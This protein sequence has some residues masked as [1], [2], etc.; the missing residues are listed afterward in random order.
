M[1]T[2]LRTPVL[3]LASGFL[4]VALPSAAQECPRL[5][6]KF[7]IPREP[8]TSLGP[9]QF[10]ELPVPPGRRVLITDVYIHN[11]EGVGR[12]I[13]EIAEQTG[14]NSFEI[15]YSYFVEPQ[16]LVVVNYTSGLRLGDL[17]R[18]AGSIRLF[19]R[20]DATGGLLVRVNGCIVP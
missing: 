19:N 15:R 6:S 14:P 8:E 5:A 11:L 1:W 4:L 16:Q 12:G 10:F 18:I 2:R 9:G 13:L 7:S 17:N 20:N 3:F